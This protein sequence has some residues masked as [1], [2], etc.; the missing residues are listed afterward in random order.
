[1]GRHGS[2]GDGVIPTRHERRAS[3]E[4]WKAA[5]TKHGP[6]ASQPSS[7]Q[8]CQGAKS[9]RNLGPMQAKVWWWSSSRRSPMKLTSFYNRFKAGSESIVTVPVLFS[10]PPPCHRPHRTVPHITLPIQS[11]LVVMCFQVGVRD[12]NRLG[13]GTARDRPRQLL[14]STATVTTSS[15]GPGSRSRSSRDLCREKRWSVVVRHGTAGR[16]SGARCS[17]RRRHGYAV[18]IGIASCIM[19][20]SLCSASFRTATA[21]P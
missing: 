16:A 3:W 10:R 11:S 9:V 17:A 15:T 1:M 4:R 20:G 19:E 5:N 13:R 6:E 14:S 18:V 21:T 8:Q 7:P 12:K 2:L